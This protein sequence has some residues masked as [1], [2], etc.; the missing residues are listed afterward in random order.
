LRSDTFTLPT[1]SMY[2]AVCRAPLGDDIYRE[3]PTV[4]RLERLAARMVG[5]EAALLVTSGTQAN[6]VALLTHCPR[7]S[8]VVVGAT[9]DVLNWEVS[10][11]AAL[12]GLMPRAVPDDDGYPNPDEVR[13]AIRP[14]DVHVGPTGLICVENTHQRSGGRPIPL[15]I[16]AALRLVSIERGVPIHMDG[17]RLF[18]AA[19]A[20]GRSAADIAASVTSVSFCLSKGL[21]APIGSILCGTSEFIERARWTR[22]MLGGGM[23][24]AGW[25]A[26]AGIVALE[27]NVNRL[28]DDHANA[29]H[30]A[31]GLGRLAGLAVDPAA[32]VTNIVLVDVRPS[33]RSPDEL[34]DRLGSRGVRALAAGSSH[35]RLVTHRGVGRT[36]VD[37]AVAAFSRALA[38]R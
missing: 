28:E 8:E 7:G 22:K 24:Q 36:D 27:Q 12:G 9:S 32:V 23:R 10:G 37:A 30:L 2:E 19:V 29:R 35:V 38:D 5:K 15:S 26:A 33:G 17:A 11:M 25:I 1:E 13:A 4:A 14:A 31:A 34:V 21:S 3:D 20:L 18:N 6:L 16:L